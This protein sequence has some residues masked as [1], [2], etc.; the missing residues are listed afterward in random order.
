MTQV[1]KRQYADAVT[2]M[3]STYSS[4]E[5]VPRHPDVYPPFVIHVQFI[6]VVKTNG[7][8]RLMGDLSTLL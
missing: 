1:C 3:I 6:Q 8:K 2:R 7:F 5:K 4:D